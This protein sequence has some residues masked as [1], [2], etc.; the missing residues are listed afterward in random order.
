MQRISELPAEDSPGQS[1]NGATGTQQGRAS[2]DG[3]SPSHAQA[4]KES[5][6][7][8]ASKELLHNA[9]SMDM[10]GSDMGRGDASLHNNS[11]VAHGTSTPTLDAQSHFQQQ[12]QQQPGKGRRQQQ[13]GEVDPDDEEHS[14]LESFACTR[15]S[16]PQQVWD[17]LP[18]ASRARNTENPNGAAPQKNR[19]SIYGLPM[20]PPYHIVSISWM[21]LMLVFDVVYTVGAGC[22]GD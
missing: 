17:R 12:Q 4:A 20:I 11:H 9:K 19:R 6:L 13:E 2:T 10:G 16:V 22:A 21:T 18:V 5:G 7:G 15:I 3:R 8:L 1:P 14:W